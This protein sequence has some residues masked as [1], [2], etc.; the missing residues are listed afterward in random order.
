VVGRLVLDTESVVNPEGAEIL[1]E[2]GG[3]QYQTALVSVGP[4]GFEYRDTDGGG[5]PWR[6]STWITDVQLESTNQVRITLNQAPL[7]KNRYLRYAGVALPQSLG[8]RGGP[9]AGPRGCLRDEDPAPSLYGETLYNWCV[10]FDER[11][12]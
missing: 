6:C 1:A 11:V 8:G 2:Y 10:H 3:P 7:G 9:E 4:S 12:P 5:D